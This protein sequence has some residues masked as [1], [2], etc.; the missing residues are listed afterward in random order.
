MPKVKQEESA[1][2]VTKTYDFALW[3][4]PKVETF[5]R[6]HRFTIGD[7]LADTSLDLLMALVQA[8]YSQDKDELLHEASLKANSL[9]YLLR[10]SKD[11]RLINIDSYEH[12]AE[13]LEEIGRMIGGWQRSLRR[14]V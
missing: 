3:L 8:A 4:F 14:R 1:V 10:L 12:S 7:R 2:V 9:R 11:L 13:R 6:S 5:R